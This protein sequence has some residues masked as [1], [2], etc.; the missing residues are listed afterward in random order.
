MN[1]KEAVKIIFGKKWLVF[2][3]AVLGA[4]LVFDLM[5][6]QAPN[7]KSNSKI[8]VI[9]KQVAGQDIYTVSKSAQYLARILKEGIYS[10][11]F[12]EKI[13]ESPYGVE[14]A[15]FPL[16]PKERRK[17]WEKSVRAI[18][19]RDLGVMEINVFYPEKEKAE[20]ISRA[21]TDV[22]SAEHTFYHGG[23]ENV[24][25]RILDKP[26]VSEKPITFNLWLGSV[27]GALLGFLLGSGW[28]LRK[29]LRGER[30]DK[31]SGEGFTSVGDEIE[32]RREQENE[33]MARREDG[34][35]F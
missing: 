30:D 19:V 8:L 3:A 7:Y 27:L 13:I 10:D 29:W 14:E 28:A 12:F 5:V 24:V 35:Y 6:I 20:Q 31:R 15:D 2:W 21:I 9:Q 33:E 23:G 32:K 25:L 4:V 17:E 18:I 22:L 34:S 26:L 1:Y 11:S 16:K